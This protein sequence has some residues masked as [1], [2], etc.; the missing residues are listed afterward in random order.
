MDSGQALSGL[1]AWVIE[2][3]DNAHISLVDGEKQS[4]LMG[5]MFSCNSS[6]VTYTCSLPT[7]SSS[8]FR[9]M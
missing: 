2:D 4:F 6:L 7:A 3:G 9:F 5:C 1:E 8:A